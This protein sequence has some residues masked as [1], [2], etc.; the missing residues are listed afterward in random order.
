MTTL[1]SVWAN[2]TRRSH[3]HFFVVP[4]HP[5]LVRLQFGDGERR[6]SLC[7]EYTILP[8]HPEAWITDDPAKSARKVCLNCSRLFFAPEPPEARR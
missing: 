1:P 7:A 6:V 3:L 4:A 5:N 8:D 2:P